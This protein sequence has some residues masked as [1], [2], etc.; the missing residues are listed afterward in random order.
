MT[1]VASLNMPPDHRI[2][3]VRHYDAGPPTGLELV[4]ICDFLYIY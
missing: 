2:T 3:A 4:S 1:E